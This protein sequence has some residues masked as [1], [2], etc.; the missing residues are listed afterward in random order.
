MSD[1]YDFKSPRNG[2]WEPFDAGSVCVCVC[3]S[4]L[5]RRHGATLLM[6]H[7]RDCVILTC[8][9][10]EG[11]EGGRK[12]RNAGGLWCRKTLKQGGGAPRKEEKSASGKKKVVGR[13]YVL[14]LGIP[15]IQSNVKFIITLTANFD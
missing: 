8:V 3:V 2:A 11:M 5:Q 6:S 13:D 15:V 4:H 7:C 14:G 1:G 9:W 10:D 12:V